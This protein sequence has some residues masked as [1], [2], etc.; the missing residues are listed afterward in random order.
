MTHGEKAKA[1]TAKSSQASATKKISTKAG[2]KT[3]QIGKKGGGK[4][5][6][7]SSKAVK[8]GGKKAG[9]EKTSAKTSAK[10]GSQKES[11]A[12]IPAK[13]AAS[14]AK[15][16]GS[17]GKAKARPP[18]AEEAAGFTNPTVANAFKRA[19]KKYPNAF[20]KLTD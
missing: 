20:R 14:A 3:V 4:E 17:N 6:G 1:K 19:L 12:A 13:K 18:A 2:T 5:T 16:T 15:E 11:A 8:A 9:P 7:Q 10:A